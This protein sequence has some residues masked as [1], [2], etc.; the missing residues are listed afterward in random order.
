MSNTLLHIA[1]RVLNR[2]LL[3]TPEKA[4]VIMSV[5]AGRIGVDA[6]TPDASRFAPNE[7]VDA[8]GRPTAPYSRTPEGVG[9]L[10]IAGSLVN[11][12]AWIGANSGLVSYEGIKHQ[13]ASVAADPKV[14]SAILDLSSP[15]G[16]AIGAF[17]TAEAVR[18]LARVK[19]TVAVVNGMA[20]SAAYAIAS[21]ATEIVTTETGVAGSIGVV[22]LHADY[23]ANLATEGI[24]PTLIFA[25][26]HKVDGNPFEP[27]TDAVK[28]DL[29]AEVNAFY[30]K[31]LGTVEA[32]RGARTSRDKARAT[33]AR[34]FIGEAVVAAGLADRV[35][36]FESVL[37][38][39][40]KAARASGF[41]STKKGS[42]QMDDAATAARPEFY[43]QMSA[44]QQAKYDRE[45][46]AGMREGAAEVQARIKSIFA[47]PAIAGDGRRMTAAAE[48]ALKAPDM[49]AEDVVQFIAST[50]PRITALH[51]SLDSRGR[52]IVLGW[53][54]PSTKHDATLRGEA[55]LDAT[56]IYRRR[57]EQMCGRVANV[58]P[59]TSA[60]KPALDAE[61][62][63]RRCREQR[64]RKPTVK[65]EEEE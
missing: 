29:Q 55:T 34:T 6:P 13:I 3:I 27:L 49:A 20:A 58:K 18:A 56:E 39:L 61:E 52:S 12:G 32:G 48:L 26:A 33:E 14:H 4:A 21:G 59:K 22:L 47:H 15:G 19:H 28:S 40:T 62:I 54:L 16:E 44:V 36:T 35:G 31:F 46:E 5:L 1:D 64:G 42:R 23:S 17:E 57:R 51:R 53:K 24:K 2:P 63:Y 10:T 9:V 65:R 50:M 8:R 25:G 37:A 43:H 60:A 41:T 7:L 45:F 30:E 11:R 38:D